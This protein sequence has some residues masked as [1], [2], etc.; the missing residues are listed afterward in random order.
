MWRTDQTL[1]RQRQR[2]CGIGLTIA[3]ILRRKL[4]S[5]LAIDELEAYLEHHLHLEHLPYTG[6]LKAAAYVLEAMHRKGYSVTLSLS[7]YSASIAFL[8]VR[9]GRGGC[10]SVPTVNAAEGICEAAYMALLMEESKR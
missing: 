5:R 8:D 1:C 7:E 4:M 9:N 2:N 10:C 3:A 6:N